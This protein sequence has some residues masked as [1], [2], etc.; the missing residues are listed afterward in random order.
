A[1]SKRSYSGS[2][3][4]CAPSRSWPTT[5]RDALAVPRRDRLQ[6]HSAVHATPRCPQQG[7]APDSRRAPAE[8]VR[9]FAA[10]TPFYPPQ[11]GPETARTAPQ[12]PSRLLIR[13]KIH[14]H[15]CSTTV[16][17]ISRLAYHA[18]RNMSK[19]S[20]TPR[21]AW[22]LYTTRAS[23]PAPPLRSRQP[24]SSTG[25]FWCTRAWRLWRR[26]VPSL[27]GEG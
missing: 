18:G 2:L 17:E 19:L 11:R 8:E 7:A 20:T 27:R 6:A 5:P 26:S 13:A 16:Y 12:S 23:A 21:A 3:P 15:R 14:S 9:A 1:P 4:C 22:R 24:R 25:A 10:A